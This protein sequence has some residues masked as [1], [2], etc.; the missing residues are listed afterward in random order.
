MKKRFCLLTFFLFLICRTVLHSDISFLSADLNKDGDILFSIKTE[1]FNSY[2]YDTLFLY[3]KE[4][5]KTEQLTFFAEKM[6]FFKGSN[7]LQILNR[8]G[9]MRLDLTSNKTELLED[10]SPFPVPN[11]LNLHYL[12]S[13]ETSPDGRWLTM[14]EPVSPVYGR[15]ILIDTVTEKRHLL[16]EKAVRNS[17]PVRW[18]P[19]S[20][21]LLYEDSSVIYFAR[22]EWFSGHPL[23]KRYRRLGEGSVKNVQWLSASEFVFLSGNVFYKVNSI[24][25]F[26]KSFYFPLFQAGEF[27]AQLPVEFNE[28][29][30]FIS[31]SPA[32]N[33]AVFISAERNIYY[34]T[35]SPGND[36]SDS[37]KTPAVPYFLL[38]G[39]TAG[40]S[41]YWK[42]NTPVLFSNS[43]LNGKSILTVLQLS[44]SSMQFEKKAVFTE[45]TLLS[46]SPGFKTALIKE[47]GMLSFYDTDLWIK[48]NSF[49]EEQIFSSVWKDDYTFFLGGEKMLYK[50]AINK[51]D[52][53]FNKK[54]IGITSVT[55]YGWSS[56]GEKIL[57]KTNSGEEILEY[58]YSYTWKK[59]EQKKLF[60][61]NN[62]NTED[63]IYIDAGLS[64]FKNMIYIR[65]LKNFT[66]KPLFIEP[67]PFASKLNKP[68]TDSYSNSSSVFVHGNR[69]GKKQAAL[70]FDAMDTMDGIAE[71]LYILNKY[72]IKATFFINGEA[73][74]RNPE[75]AKEI[76][77]SGHQCGSLFFTA[78]N[79]ND[80]NYTINETFVRQG[81]AKNEDAFYAV[82]G[83][84][85]SLIWHS[86]DYI[87]SQMILN[88]GKKAGYIFISPD[89]RIPDWIDAK[90]ENT[91]PMLHKSSIEIIEDIYSAI[92]PGSIIPIRLGKP[93]LKK[94]DYL[95]T[96]L[97]FLINVLAEAGYSLTDVKTLMELN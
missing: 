36:Y 38:P 22:P 81:L 37:K 42:N 24:E 97:E 8:F 40:I 76:V 23:D 94:K 90:T 60:K 65:S 6:N 78:W 95:Y 75:A 16:S 74:K 89:I 32:G 2:A 91:V 86:P 43:I 67:L 47:N 57:S 79:L 41:V 66:T 88:A 31:V 39:N 63:R 87:I 70:V 46:A 51:D 11:T 69:S 72:G 55:D 49:N 48:I 52:S 4:K 77:R 3:S 26:T 62:S 27:M 1:V 20:K 5:N 44:P 13:I 30:D 96:R 9:I 59:S 50:C 82:T 92:L 85:L 14:I 53:F 73:L 45:A 15:L 58:T 35:L 93:N 18:A 83:A 68:E 80:I 28:A 61:K 12:D 17:N 64:Y 71:I 84:E 21:T 19:D 10:F 7:T 54:Q 34:L 29:A 33:S 25:L 56:G